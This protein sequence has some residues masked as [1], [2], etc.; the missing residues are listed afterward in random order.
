MVV[1]KT[2]QTKKH[3]LNIPDIITLL[4]IL[5]TLTIIFL[6]PLSAAFFC[7]YVL[8]GITDVLDG[9]IARKTHTSSDFGAKLDSIADLLFYSVILLRLFPA[10][11]RVLPKSIWYAV[12][13]ILITRISAYMVAAV[14]YRRFASLH[15][16]LNKLT[17]LVVFAVPFALVTAYAE[18]YCGIVCV[19][20]SVAVLEELIIHIMRPSYNPNAKSV[21]CK[22]EMQKY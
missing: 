15:T 5:G 14:K 13:A 7:V 19:I 2:E 9:W 18:L 10:L 3:K 12:A 17:G 22:K 1:M 8:T 21:F 16:Y 4:R 20:A 6:R 11:W